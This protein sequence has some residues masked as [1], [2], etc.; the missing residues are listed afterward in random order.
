MIAVGE[1]GITVKSSVGGVFEI[2]FFNFKTQNVLSTRDF[3]AFNHI[4]RPR[5]Y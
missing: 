1:F 5:T 4:D 2:R 3:P